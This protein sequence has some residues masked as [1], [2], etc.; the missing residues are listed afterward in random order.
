MP[1][2]SPHRLSPR[3]GLTKQQ[4]RQ[5][6]TVHK[7]LDEVNPRELPEV[8]PP[9]EPAAPP[10]QV[11]RAGQLVLARS[12][13]ITDAFDGRISAF[14]AYMQPRKLRLT[15]SGAPR[16]R[17]VRTKELEAYAAKHALSAI[18]AAAD[19]VA[20]L[21]PSAAQA[22]HDVPVHGVHYD[23]EQFLLKISH[24]CITKEQEAL[25]EILGH[26]P[27]E[28]KRYKQTCVRIGKLASQPGGRIYNEVQEIDKMLSGNHKD[29]K[30]MTINLL[31][32]SPQD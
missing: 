22:L 11:F 10:P 1:R 9:E 21:P 28:L 13:E 27:D 18:D 19:I 12:V 31:P 15:R 2:R 5:V 29:D 8:I 32:A 25:Q 7:L 4:S 23:G 24:E 14:A 30:P 26:E 6:E 3:S 20:N 16:T 17:Y